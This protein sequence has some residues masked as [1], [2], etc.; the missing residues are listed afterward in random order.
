MATSFSASDLHRRNPASPADAKIS[1]MLRPWSIDLFIEIVKLQPQV[2]RQNPA[3]RAF[4]GSRR[5]VNKYEI[6]YMTVVA[7]VSIRSRRSLSRST[8]LPMNSTVPVGLWRIW[9]R[10]GLSTFNMTGWSTIA[11]ISIITTAEAAAASVPF[12]STATKALWKTLSIHNSLHHPSRR[13]PG[14]RYRKH[15]AFPDRPA[16]R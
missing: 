16:G 6:P 4:P 9:N 12:S 14:F 11:D 15:P 13:N 7:L 10:N 2:F 3:D 8:T 1:G 5:A